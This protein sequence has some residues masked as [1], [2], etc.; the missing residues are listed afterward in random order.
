MKTLIAVVILMSLS[1]CVDGRL[2]LKL[3]APELAHK[4]DIDP[5]YPDCLEPQPIF[6][7][8]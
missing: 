5:Y 7:S 8:S 3:H 1:G 2:D 6:K 4:C